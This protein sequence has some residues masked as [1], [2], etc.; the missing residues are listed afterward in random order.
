MQIFKRTSLFLASLLVVGLS[1]TQI[2]V[3]QAD[4]EAP[5]Y[6]L[7]VHVPKALPKSAKVTISL[8]SDSSK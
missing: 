4:S 5:K 3:S 8:A 7:V 1:L 6:D 2:T